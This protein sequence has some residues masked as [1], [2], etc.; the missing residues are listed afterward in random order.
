MSPADGGAGVMLESAAPCALDVVAIGASAGGVAALSI[1]LSSLAAR[2]PAA[3]VI[4][5]HLHPD[6]RSHLAD[7]LARRCR[8]P[9]HEARDGE[10]LEAGV[11]YIAPPR[12]HLA[13]RG[14]RLILTDARPVHYV[15]PSIDVLFASVAAACGPRAVGVILTG[16]GRD[17]AD[18]VRAIK[19]AHG[20][21]VVQDPVG[22]E[23]RGMPAAAVATG[24]A[25]LTLPL[26][27]I[28]A[29][30]AS[31][32]PTSRIAAAGGTSDG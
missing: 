26:A 28:G 1:I 11:V 24:C 18:G 13:L 5:Q 29:A 32:V 21:V 23:S 15:R 30:L 7:V 4:V 31:L 20:H 27:E 9:V 22:A 8:L 10:V 14:D 2:F 25:D 3:V 19:H 6:F 12:V 16:W 17:G